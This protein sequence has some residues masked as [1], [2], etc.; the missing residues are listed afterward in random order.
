MYELISAFNVIA[1]KEWVRLA[2]LYSHLILCAFA[3]AAVLK[4][5]VAL[6]FS[7]IN[8]AQLEKTAHRISL[9]L[10]A[11]WASGLAIIYLDT[12]FNPDILATKSKLMFK[13]ACVCVLTVNGI[14]LHHVSFP[15]LVSN[16]S[17]LS[18]LDTLLLVVTG[19]LS[20]SHWLLAA[21]VGLA[22]PLGRLPLEVLLTAYCLFLV[23]VVL[24]SIMTLPLLSKMQVMNVP[25]PAH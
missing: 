24:A 16:K 4:T 21:F 19:G 15:V 17:T 8:Q 1:I 14:V 7:R 3:I 25:Q 23:S 11:L 13:L 22:K 2:L 9:L 10:V 12:G 5:D 20:T 6:L 18:S